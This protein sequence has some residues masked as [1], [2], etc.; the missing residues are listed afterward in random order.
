MSVAVGSISD[1]FRRA[2]A[3][4]GAVAVAV[5][6]PEEA[7]RLHLW[8]AAVAVGSISDF[9]W[10]AS[11]EKGAVAVAEGR[12]VEALRLHLWRTNFV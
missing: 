6:R 7:L 9:F 3:K 4:K 8:R 5:A 12:P 10:R 11:A 2:S 1:F